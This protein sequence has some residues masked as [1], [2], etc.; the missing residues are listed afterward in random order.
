MKLWRT[1]WIILAFLFLLTGGFVAWGL[2]PAP[3]MPEALAALRSDERV[4]VSDS[5]WLVFSPHFQTPDTAL[6]F[7]PGG[8]VDPRAYAPLA[9]QIAEQGFL[10]VIPP[11][12]LNLA[13]FAPEIAL[14]ILQEYPAIK[15]WVIGGHSLGGAMAANFVKKHPDK[16]QG[17]I[18][19]ASYPAESDSL[20]EI[21]T[22]K[23]LSIYASLDGLAT[24]EKVLSSRTL[25]PADTEWVEISGGNHAQFGWYGDQSRDRPAQIPREQQQSQIVSTILEFLVHLKD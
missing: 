9:R 19:L 15:T 22:L 1:F 24:P 25:L 17:L 12:P 7:Y 4:E 14:E 13:V 2:T 21:P 23:V 5:R 8:R 16:V 6:I 18:L 3:P 10:V 20:R 11:M